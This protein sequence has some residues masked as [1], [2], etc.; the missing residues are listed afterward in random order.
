[1]LYF[2]YDN[3]SHSKEDREVMLEDLAGWVREDQLSLFIEMYD[4]DDFSYALDKAQLPFRR[5]K[6]VLNMDY[7][8][9]M[10]EHDKMAKTDM[11][12][13]YTYPFEVDP[14]IQ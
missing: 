14:N 12:K 5:R 4:F 9:R 7:P 10:A 1:M 13:Y 6:V 8:D 11:E 3:P 2:H